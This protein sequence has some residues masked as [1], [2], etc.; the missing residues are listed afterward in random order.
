MIQVEETEIEFLSMGLFENEGP[1]KHPEI[2]KDSYEIIY[3]TEGVVY[4]YEDGVEYELPKGDLL[5]MRPDI[6]HRGYRESAGRTQFYWL[7]FQLN[8]R[9]GYTGNPP[10]TRHIH[11]FTQAALFKELLHYSHSTQKNR[12]MR[13][14]VLGYLLGQIAAHDAEKETDK[15]SAEVFEW[16]RINISHK[17]TVKKTAAHFQYNQDYLSKIIKRQYGMT[18]KELIN[19]FLIQKANDYLCNTVYTVKEISVLLDFPSANIF[20]NYY[21]YHQKMTPTAFRNKYT[22]I[23]MNNK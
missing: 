16:V 13:D 7:H 3:V 18:L 21:K 9:K 22:H 4:M 2:A 8:Y 10:N 20:V 23:V 19:S 15:L 12:Y 5:L 6:I 14:I 17:L 1:W 11:T